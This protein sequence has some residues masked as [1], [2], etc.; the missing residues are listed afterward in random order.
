MQSIK[1]LMVR[2]KERGAAHAPALG[3][4]PPFVSRTGSG[5]QLAQDMVQDAAVAE[6]LDFVERIDPAH[7]RHLLDR[8][9]RRRD[10]GRHPLARL[11]VAREAPDRDGLVA[12]EAE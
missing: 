3:A 5:R 8:A 6:I 11:E 2:A 1:S 9:V 7:Q 10:L 4:I 12:L